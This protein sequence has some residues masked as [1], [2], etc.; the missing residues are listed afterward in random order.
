MLLPCG[1]DALQAEGL[2]RGEH[3]PDEDALPFGVAAMAGLA[4]RYLDGGAPAVPAGPA[5]PGT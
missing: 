1:A 5:P 3:R 2:A 4:L